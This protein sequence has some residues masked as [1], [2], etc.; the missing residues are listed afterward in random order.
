MRIAISGMFW[1][2]PHVGSGQYLHN[3]VREFAAGDSRDKFVLVL[4]RFTKPV[5]P[6]LRGVQT[7]IMPTPFDGINHNLAKVWFEQVALLQVAHKVRAERLHVP[8]FGPPRYTKLPL[9]VSVL[10][11]IPLLLPAYRGGR[12]VRQYMRLA[13]AGTVRAQAVIAI[14]D[15]TRQDVIRTL[16]VPA[17]RIAVTYLAAAP[18]YEVQT[19]A[20]VSAVRARF[21]LGER[22]I[23]YI[24]GFDVR[25]NVATLLRAFAEVLRT[26]DAPLQLVLAGRPAGSDPTLFPDLHQLVLRAGDCAGG[27][28]ARAGHG[29]RECRADDWRGGV[30]VSL[31]LRRLWA[32]SAGGDA[33]GGGGRGGEHDER[34]RGRR[35]RR[36]AG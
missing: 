24:G 31:D 28:D 5:R 34:R 25:K 1:S 2:E 13:A 8:Y 11:L 23:Y 7:V 29:G 4:P 9:V 20:A 3:L 18:D 35:R 33:V 22:Y 12:L 6:R 15:Y 17:D 36:P 26:A 21:R 19:D 14:S 32:N 30:R 16:D 27:G 10:D